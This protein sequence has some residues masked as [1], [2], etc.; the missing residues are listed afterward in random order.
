[1]GRWIGVDL[2]GTLAK[3]INSNGTAIGDPVFSMLERVELWLSRGR[4]V[5]IFTARASD[6]QQVASIQ[7][8]LKRHGIEECGITDRKDLEM[9]EFYDDKARRVVADTGRL[10][11]GCR[12][13]RRSLE[14]KHRE[15]ATGEA[16]LT[17]C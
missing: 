8:W 1:M 2:D 7:A 6:P 15:H 10:C 12:P 17:D 11:S 14:R 5:R 9:I 3:S 4:E 16:L 13:S